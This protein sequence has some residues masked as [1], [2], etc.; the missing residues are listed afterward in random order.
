M[1]DAAIKAV[2]DAGGKVVAERRSGKVLLV[3]I[4]VEDLEK[5]AALQAVTRIEPAGA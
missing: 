3:S 4:R 5:L 1:S 2:K